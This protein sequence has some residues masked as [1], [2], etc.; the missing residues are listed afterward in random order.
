MPIIAAESGAIIIID[1]KNLTIGIIIETII[2]FSL[3][4]FLAVSLRAD[5]PHDYLFAFFRRRML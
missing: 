2:F 3:K 4:I 5:Y 1:T